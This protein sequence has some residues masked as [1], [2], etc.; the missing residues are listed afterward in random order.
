[1]NRPIFLIGYM[2]SGKTTLGRALAPALG[3]TFVDLD[4]FIEQ[5]FHCTI[6]QYFAANGE[7][8]FR[9]I[10]AAALREV[11]EL[12]N[13]VV[14]C[15]G[16][17]PCF[18]SNMQYMNEKGLTIRLKASDECLLQ[19]L[20]RRREKRPLLRDKTDDEILEMIRSH[21]AARE[22]AYCMAALTINADSLDSKKGI[23]DTVVQLVNS[24]LDKI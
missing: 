18:N 3:R 4:F 16:G 19:R 22:P 10:E 17:T 24:Y 23:S 8:S 6:A 2:G 11:G 5:R 13:I 7:E 14:A 9:R 15:G 12:E 1:M 20:T 21:Q